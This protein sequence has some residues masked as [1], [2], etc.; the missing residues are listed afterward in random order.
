MQGRH[1]RGLLGRSATEN[2]PEGPKR[3]SDRFSRLSF[4]NARLAAALL[5]LA[6]PASAYLLELDLNVQDIKRLSPEISLP[7]PTEKG[8]ITVISFESLI[9]APDRETVRRAALADRGLRILV[10]KQ[11]FDLTLVR[12]DEVL[13]T[14]PVA[15]GSGKTFEKDGRTFTFDTPIGKRRVIGKERDPYWTPPDW[16]Y[17]EIASTNKL[18][19]VFL[20]RGHPVT[21]ADGRVLEVRGPE[22]GVTDLQGVWAPMVLG[23]EIVFDDTLFVPPVD[24]NQ[25]RSKGVLGPFKLDMGGGFLIHGVNRGT[26]S[27]IGRALSHGCVRLPNDRL[28]ELYPLVPVGT[29][30]YI[31]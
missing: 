20:K 30:V 22:V 4:V 16:H 23:E 6:Q 5:L 14:A 13:F 7:P 17:Y 15:I 10:D 26:A 24:T 9:Q 2:L 12:G 1:S 31:Y 29:P 18:E 28:T 8:S 27:S 11:S 21:L 19:L 3:G 25:R